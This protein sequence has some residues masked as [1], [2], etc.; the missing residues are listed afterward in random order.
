MIV[1]KENRG[2][3]LFEVLIA[4][5]IS[6]MVINLCW[7]FLFRSQKM[8]RKIAA[9]TELQFQAQYILEYMN[10]KI[11]N[12]S[13]I[14]LIKK[15]TIN[16]IN[17]NKEETFTEIAFK[18]GED[19]IYYIFSFNENTKKIFYTKSK[20]I[21]GATSELGNC[22]KS[23]TITPLPSNST[24]NSCKGVLIKIFLEKEEM[25][26]SAE[27]LIFMR[28]NKNFKMSNLNIL[29]SKYIFC[30]LKI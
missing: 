12:A 1:Y 3:T 7:M 18:C 28:N 27:Q 15:N 5:G 25:E 4:L 29:Y 9:D 22:V 24:F 2:V 21:K 10:D 19:N 8:Y 11:I 13:N 6:I 23:M 14:S 26:Y 20:T 30:K 16:L 17:S